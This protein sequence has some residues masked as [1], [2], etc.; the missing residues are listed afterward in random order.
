MICYFDGYDYT[1]TW[2]SLPWRKKCRR[3]T[4]ISSSIKQV[5]L[6]AGD[7]SGQSLVGVDCDERAAAHIPR[8]D[9]LPD[10]GDSIRPGNYGIP[11][12]WYTPAMNDTAL[13]MKCYFL[14]FNIILLTF[15][16]IMIIITADL[17]IVILWFVFIRFVI[18]LFQPG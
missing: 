13:K 17:H 10:K 5:E 1:V 7:G 4:N 9:P 11:G 3:K 8:R 18:G 12:A 15:H 14:A 16:N 6:H 2:F